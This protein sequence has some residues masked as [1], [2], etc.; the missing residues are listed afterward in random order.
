[1]RHLFGCLQDD[2]LRYGIL[3]VVGDAEGVPMLA[4]SKQRDENRGRTPRCRATGLE[5]ST[6]SME[7]LGNGDFAS[8]GFEDQCGV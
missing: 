5:C 8:G 6:E 4:R 7:A 1:M 2:D 3:I